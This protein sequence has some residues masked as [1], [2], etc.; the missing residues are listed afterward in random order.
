MAGKELFTCWSQYTYIVLGTPTSSASAADRLKLRIKRS[1]KV[2][3]PD[4]APPGCGDGDAPHCARRSA[5][6]H[7]MY[8][9]SRLFSATS[10]EVV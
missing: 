4:S 7:D 1:E 6:D 8:S 2:G 5:A 10:L 3:A 9:P